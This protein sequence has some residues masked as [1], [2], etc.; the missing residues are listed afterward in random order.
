MEGVDF[1]AGV[2]GED[3]EVGRLLGVE[4]GFK[5]GVAGE[6]GGVF[7]GREDEGEVGEREDLDVGGSGG[8]GE[9]AEFAGVGGGGVEGDHEGLDEGWRS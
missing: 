4:D 8:G 2:V 5:A 1:E 6:A 3:E 9:L 7:V